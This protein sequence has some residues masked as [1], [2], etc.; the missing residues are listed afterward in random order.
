M[1]QAQTETP[2]FTPMDKTKPF[3]INY[4]I[5]GISFS[6]NPSKH[7]SCYTLSV[8]KW[9]PNTDHVMH[10]Q[11]SGGAIVIS[12]STKLKFPKSAKLCDRAVYIELRK[13]LHDEQAIRSFRDVVSRCASQVSCV[14][15]P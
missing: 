7:P 4:P 6:Y 1:F 5:A 9:A 8:D 10:I 15:A 14:K 13:R 12:T 2:D 3:S 11:D